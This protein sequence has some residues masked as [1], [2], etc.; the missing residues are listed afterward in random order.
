MKIINGK[1]EVLKFGGEVMKNV[2]SP[3][4][5]DSSY[6]LRMQAQLCKAMHSMGMY[7]T[8][9]A[10]LRNQSELS[11]KHFKDAITSSQEDKSKVELQILNELMAV[12]LERQDAEG[13]T[14]ELMDNF[15][16]ERD[17]L[18]DRI[19]REKE[20]PP[21]EDDEE[22]R[23]E[24]MEILTQ[25]REEIERMEQEN[26]EELEQLEAL[27]E[28]V[29]AIK[30]EGFVEDIVSSIVEE[31]KERQAEEESSEEEEDD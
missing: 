13:K 29:I 19:E 20:E 3:E 1:A 25:G 17:S 8:Q 30:G 10:L 16:K 24:L 11:Q 14:K 2:A 22:E 5:R 9:L 21:E 23:E 12:D 28:K 18:L 31:F 27:K 26:K 7:E 4:T 15:T 6:V